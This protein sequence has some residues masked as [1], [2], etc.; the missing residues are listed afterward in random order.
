MVGRR[1]EGYIL[2]SADGLVEAVF[3]GSWT[4]VLL[5]FWLVVVVA[6]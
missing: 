1:P 2:G 4:L 6:R 5:V 3:D